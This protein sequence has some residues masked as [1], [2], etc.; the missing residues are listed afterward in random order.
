MP[1]ER[2]RPAPVRVARVL[3]VHLEG[4]Y[5]HPGGWARSRPLRARLAGRDPARLHALAPIRVITL[6]PEL[7]GALALIPRWRQAGLR[8]QIGHSAASYEQ[9]CSGAAARRQ[10]LHAPVQRHGPVPPPRT[11]RGRRGAGPCRQAE[12]IPDLLHVHPAPSAVRCAPCPA[13]T[14]VTDATAAAGMPDGDYRLGRQTVRKCEGGVRLA[15][16]T[17]AGSTLTMDQ[18]LRNLVSLGLPL[19]D[20][21]RRTSTHAADYLGL[22]DRGRLQPGAW[23][24]L[25]QL[26]PTLQLQRVIVEGEEIDLSDAAEALQAPAAVARACWRPIDEAI[27][28]L[29]AGCADPAPVALL[30]V[31]RGSSDHAAH[32][33]AYL[34]MA[35]LGRLV[36]S[37]PMSLI[38]L[39]QAAAGR[40]AG[41]AGVLAVGPEPGPGGAHALAARA[42]HARWPSSTTPRSPL[43][44]AADGCCRCTPG[45]RSAAWRPPRATSRSWWPAR[46]WWRLAAGRCLLQALAAL[47]QALHRAA[48]LDWS[49][50]CRRCGAPSACSSSARGTGPA[51]GHGSGAEVQG[52]LRHP[53][54]GL[55]RRRGPAW[56]DG[57]GGPGYPLLVFAPRGPAQAGL[58]QLAEDMRGRGAQVL[59]AAPRARP[60]P[61]WLPLA[62]TGH[63]DLDPIAAMQ[64]FYPM[65]EALARARG[66]DPDRP[67]TWPR[68]PTH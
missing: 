25:V 44:Q 4:P 20:A 19:A 46:A 56:A 22:A 35:R 9:A 41:V 53:G 15:D 31:A 30:T 68:S 21:S 60:A 55:Q 59:L 63:E 51:G 45:P 49:P 52:N 29:G 65:V 40:G 39:Y 57:A 36:T 24:D 26:D 66:R 47:P 27:A 13:C 34:V 43:A 11:R 6:A 33:M 10:R 50:P 42:A 3:G 28:T 2:C 5:I 1:I 8:V 61:L 37:L 18:A 38:T 62:T 58:L 12:L 17:L 32:Y 16:G 7:P 14:C 23:A 67:R 64:S 54:R 48:T